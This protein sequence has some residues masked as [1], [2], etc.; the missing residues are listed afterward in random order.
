MRRQIHQLGNG[1]YVDRLMRR[2]AATAPVWH[3]AYVLATTWPAPELPVSGADVL[4]AGL[5][6][7]RRVGVLV[8]AVERWWADHDFTPDRPACLAELR[9][10]ID[11][12]E[13]A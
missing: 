2:A 3:E 11:A 12:G 7:G 10:R 9:R 8:A 4:A 13:G 5:P 1:L 6:A